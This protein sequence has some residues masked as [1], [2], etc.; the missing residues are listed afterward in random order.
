MKKGSKALIAVIV[1]L[2]VLSPV[3][4]FPGPVDDALLAV[5][6]WYLAGR[7]QRIE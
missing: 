7:R 6:T 1:I 5:V 2:Y 3:D 4:F